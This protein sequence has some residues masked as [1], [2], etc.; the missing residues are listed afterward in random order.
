MACVTS[1]RFSR[2]C[3]ATMRSCSACA[4]GLTASDLEGDV[5]VVLNG[6]PSPWSGGEND[7]VPA[8]A[9]TKTPLFNLATPP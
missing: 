1:E 6:E 5:S 2:C 7:T 4:S 8:P 3:S 9:T